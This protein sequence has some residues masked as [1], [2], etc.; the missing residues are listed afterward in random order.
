[1]TYGKE[2]WL[3]T[4]F[5]LGT[6]PIE[7]ERLILR[8]FRPED[9][10]PMYETWTSDPIVARFMRWT[11]HRSVSETRAVVGHW[12]QCYRTGG[13]EWAVT[14]K[15]DGTLIGSIGIMDLSRS[16]LSGEAGYC[17]ARPYWNQ[18]YATEALRAVIGYM[19]RRVGLNR[20]EAFH[21]VGNPASGRVMEK[22]GMS[23]EGICRQKYQT[24][25]GLA[26][27]AHYAILAE[28]VR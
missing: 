25:D 14:L 11:T 6:H 28:D 20:I 18:G 3:L 27:C 1:M 12:V 9:A 13:Y 26:D 7:T 16:D 17:I 21:A 23:F 8:R 15:S 5:Y 4:R 2:G 22:A 24:A 19:F 10:R